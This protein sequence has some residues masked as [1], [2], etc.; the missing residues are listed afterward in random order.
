VSTGL[1]FG[2]LGPNI[3]HLCVDMQRL[4]GPESPWCSPWTERI[5]PVVEGVASHCPERTVFTRFIPPHRA[6]D[7]PGMWQHYYR[8]WHDVTRD[9]IEPDLLDLFPVLARLAPPAAVI[10][11]ATYSPF[12]SGGLAA[13]LSEHSV[14]GVIITGAETDVCILATVLGAVDRGYRAIVVTDGICSSSDPGHDAV[15]GIYHQRF[16]EQ[17]EAAN[18]EE[19]LEAWL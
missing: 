18:A 14:D 19:I 11:K 7:M 15:L 9:E 12:S 5:I 17:I 16:S 4:F 6:E 13:W 10:D 8:R 3:V 1:K 2:P